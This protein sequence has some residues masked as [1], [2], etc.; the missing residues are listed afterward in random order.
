[1]VGDADGGL[2][3]VGGKVGDV[4]GLDVGREEKVGEFEG[5]E[6]MV[7]DDEGMWLIVGWCVGD[8][9]LGEIEGE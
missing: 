8:D 2:D 4:E 7:G 6:E 9:V 3:I 5:D 1:M